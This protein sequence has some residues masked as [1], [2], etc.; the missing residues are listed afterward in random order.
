[1]GESGYF[2]LKQFFIERIYFVNCWFWT[3]LQIWSIVSSNALHVSGLVS[4]TLFLV[5]IYSIS[6]MIGCP[7]KTPI[8]LKRS[9][10]LQ[11]PVRKPTTRRWPCLVGVGSM[12]SIPTDEK[13]P[14]TSFDGTLLAPSFLVF[15]P[16]LGS[17]YLVDGTSGNSP[18]HNPGIETWSTVWVNTYYLVLVDKWKIFLGTRQDFGNFWLEYL[19]P[20]AIPILSPSPF[21]RLWIVCEPLQVNGR[22]LPPIWK[23]PRTAQ[24]CYLERLWWRAT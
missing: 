23:P 17:D 11:F 21:F 20:R 14:I 15:A 8:L 13:V 2:I 5:A 6:C 19:S 22:K 12:L 3:I 16:E 4:C 10:R 7:T 1:M 18:R 9:L 24:K